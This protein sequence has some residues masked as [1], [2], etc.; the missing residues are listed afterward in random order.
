L[1]LKN[2]EKDRLVQVVGETAGQG[3]GPFDA[4]VRLLIVDEHPLVR[5]ALRQLATQEADV[6]IVGEASQGADA[7][8]QVR[9]H[10]PNVITI[11]CSQQTADGWRLTR[12]LRGLH[13]N[14]GIV[15][16]T[17]T[18]SD[19]ELFRAL[20]TGASAFVSKSA[21]IQEIIGA[22]RHA[23]CSSTAFSAVGLGP[24][25]RRRRESGQRTALSAREHQILL[26][27]HDGLSV[28]MIAKELYVSLST[29]KTYVARLYEKLNARN[30]AQALMAAV[31]LGL[32]DGYHADELVAV[33]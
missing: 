6:T 13:P 20:D 10:Q 1:R 33:S 26:L 30:R 19:E 28:P 27:L 3:P 31:R 17:A 5:W 29:A 11:D 7:H 25:L 12:E 15:V 21:P 18:G 8:N 22:I 9:A 4:R 24:A 16:L 32:F 14:L 23:A 2:I